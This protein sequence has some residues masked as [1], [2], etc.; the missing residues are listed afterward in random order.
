MAYIRTEEVK[1]IR[2]A[3]KA[4]FPEI[5]FS[6]TCS[7][8]SKLNV[9]I[10]KSPYFDDGVEFE[11]NHRFIDKY[12]EGDSNRVLNKI[13]SIIREKGNYY[14]NSDAMTDYFDTAFYYSIK[15]GKWDKPHTKA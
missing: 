11:P 9:S 5:K 12:F 2:N 8:Y 7:N 13:N 1:I 10:M 4:E 14:D 3:L 6:V 15:V